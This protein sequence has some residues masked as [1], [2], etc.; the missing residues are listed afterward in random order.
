MH[1]MALN[2]IAPEAT[3]IKELAELVVKRYPTELSFGEPRPGDVPPAKVSAD[4]IASV[5]EWQA[6][7]PFARGLSELMEAVEARGDGALADTT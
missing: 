5:L 6:E 1:G 4:R 7:M 2:T 3:A